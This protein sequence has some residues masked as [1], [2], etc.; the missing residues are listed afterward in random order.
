MSD[1]GRGGALRQAATMVCTLGAIALLGC[2][3]LML[4]PR[5]TATSTSATLTRADLASAY[6]RIRPGLTRVS[7]FPQFG[8][9]VAAANA[10]TLTYLGVMERFMPRD[11]VQF[12]HLE[13]AVRSCM[14]AED[15]C[16]VLI[17]RATDDMN[18]RNGG[19]LLSA[20]GIGAARAGENA[21]PQMTL[22]V[23]DGTVVYKSI[24]GFALGRARPDATK[25]S[26]PD[27]TT[28]ANRAAWH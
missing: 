21:L 12:D 9:D 27:L 25:A 1:G 3:L 28:P 13:A 23:E 4:L 10:R 18:P 17:V 26:E 2:G 22:F 11:S 8:L 14:A 6:T 24:S 20:L 7:Q 16:T 5:H 15:R 19:G